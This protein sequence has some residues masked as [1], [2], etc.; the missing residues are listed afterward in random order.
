MSSIKILKYDL[1]FFDNIKQHNSFVISDNTIKII[2][3]LT[4]KLTILNKNNNFFEKNSSNKNIFN[5][6]NWNDGK[7]FKTTTF[8]KKEGLEKNINTIR[9]N[10][11]KITNKNYQTL[12]V[13]ILD[14]INNID[15]S[16]DDKNN[17]EY[18][19]TIKNLFINTVSNINIFSEIYVMLY[20]NII[21]KYDTKLFN[22]YDDFIKLKNEI[23]DIKVIQ[24]KDFATQMLDYAKKYTTLPNYN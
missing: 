12:S 1:N 2:E 14:E 13:K 16:N 10:L 6:N 3:N 22:I 15:K 7:H 21:D 19:S 5:E 18:L 20:K 11:N 9:I 4:S 24:P 23:I 17:L 8:V